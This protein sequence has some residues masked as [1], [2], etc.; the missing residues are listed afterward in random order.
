MPAD[1][2]GSAGNCVTVPPADLFWPPFAGW[3][4]FVLFPIGPVALG[5]PGPDGTVL[6]FDGDVP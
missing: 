5:C 4:M 1:A 3:D 2:G 6:A